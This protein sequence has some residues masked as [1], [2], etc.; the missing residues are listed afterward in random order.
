VSYI[1]K[2]PLLTADQTVW[3]LTKEKVTKSFKQTGTEFDFALFGGESSR[4][5]I[6]RLT[7]EGQKNDFVIGLGGGK[8]LDAAKATADKLGVPIVIAPTTASTD[9]PTSALSVIYTEEGAFESYKF[10]SRNP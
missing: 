9:A 2:R 6:D 5:E 4:K 3:D 8:T 10:Y 7:N 1:G